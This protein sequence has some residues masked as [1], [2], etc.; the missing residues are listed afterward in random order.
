MRKMYLV[1][2]VVSLVLVSASCE[3]FVE[4]NGYLKDR[5]LLWILQFLGFLSGWLGHPLVLM[6]LQLVGLGLLA[7]SSLVVEA[8][9]SRW[10]FQLLLLLELA[11]D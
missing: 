11:F 9:L 10:C 1:V 2:E 7:S 4:A 6:S 5:E 8:R 3:S